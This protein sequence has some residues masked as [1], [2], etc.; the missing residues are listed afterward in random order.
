ME[1]QN[2]SGERYGRLTA[3]HFVG[4]I[5]RGEILARAWLCRCDCGTEVII[6][7]N[8][9]YS[10]NSKSCGCLRTEIRRSKK[11]GKDRPPE[12]RV[13]I[14]MRERCNNPNCKTYK[15]YGAR[16]ITVCER[17]DDFDLFMQDMGSRPDGCTLDRINNSG[18]YSPENCRWATGI[19]QG[20]NKRNNVLVTWRDQTKTIAQW[21]R[22]FGIKRHRL[23]HYLKNGSIGAVFDGLT[24]KA[25]EST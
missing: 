25:T 10:G 17:W 16:G 18:N 24:P 11:G 21:A 9:L 2:L 20:S 15:D 12:Y 23:Y 5:R 13:W 8:N 1:T 19:E 22:Y 7:H 3:L 4:H 14:A 6:T